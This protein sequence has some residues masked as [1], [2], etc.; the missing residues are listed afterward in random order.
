MALHLVELSALKD[1]VGAGAGLLDFIDQYSEKR[2]GSLTLAVSNHK[3]FL[4]LHPRCS[5]ET[6]LAGL[7]V[8]RL[9][10]QFVGCNDTQ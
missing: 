6:V 4:R 8:L 10:H 1:L 7:T 2:Q 9:N 5:W 3:P